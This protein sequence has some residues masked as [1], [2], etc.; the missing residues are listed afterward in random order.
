MRLLNIDSLRLE[1]F[2]SS[3]NIPPYA[4]LSHTWGP[5]E[6]VFEDIISTGYERGTCRKIDGCC[7]E[8]GKWPR[9]RHVWVD[10]LCID[11]SSSAELSEAINSMFEWYGRAT[12]CFAYLGDVPSMKTVGK[13]ERLW[14][15]KFRKA[16]WFRR[17]WTL[18]EL[19]A[20][21][22]VFFY[23]EYW[24]V[25]GCRGPGKVR[26]PVGIEYDGEPPKSSNGGVQSL[27][28]IIEEVTG[29]D[30]LYL[31]GAWELGRASVAQRMSWANGR[32]TTRVEDLAY[33]LLG[34]FGINMPLL[35]GEGRKAFA[36][37]QEEIIKVSND[38]TVF[39]SHP[40]ASP[41]TV[42]AGTAG[43]TETLINSS[44][45]AKGPEDFYESRAMVPF[46]VDGGRKG[47]YMMTNNG[48]L[49]HLQ[50]I[51]LAPSSDMYLIR[52]ACRWDNIFMPSTPGVNKPA[53]TN[54]NNFMPLLPSRP[55]AILAYKP[56]GKDEDEFWRVPHRPVY[57][58][59][60]L[61]AK[62]PVEPVYL[63]RAPSEFCRARIDAN[64]HLPP[65]Y[66][67][68]GVYPPFWKGLFEID[69]NGTRG[70]VLFPEGDPTEFGPYNVWVCLSI[71]DPGTS[72]DGH[73][74]GQTCL[75]LKLNFT[76]GV[77][78]M[79]MEMGF[80]YILSRLDAK[81]GVLKG[82]EEFWGI[83]SKDLQR[84]VTLGKKVSL[85][86]LKSKF[87]ASSGSVKGKK[88]R[89][90]GGKVKFGPDAAHNGCCFRPHLTFVEYNNGVT[91]YGLTVGQETLDA[92]SPSSKGSDPSRF[93]KASTC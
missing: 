22:E 51:E 90:G 35:Y 5:D 1:T 53:I 15:G 9:I 61:F 2:P 8:A 93:W 91:A 41:S 92:P 10:T 64:I 39:V 85:E 65:G 12:V 11:K 23:D 52:L 49:A 58:S 38:Q 16:R 82:E 88:N 71:P 50:V 25:L 76:M 34:I 56:P 44:L 26:R 78:G 33:C 13:N 29:I 86:G 63:S 27:D 46:R 31:V 21:K 18:Q 14:D 83:F 20:P 67:V 48:L 69:K 72:G 75:A 79:R 81:I 6:V 84:S 24:E 62:V 42:E 66:D 3:H 30:M 80:D 60:E 28:W 37:L 73:S 4:I 57:V 19:L 47:H 55:V 7:T 45:L 32:E 74:Q 54:S 17:G 36:R 77:L 87:L 68:V 43:G 70:P 89:K 40:R 59:E